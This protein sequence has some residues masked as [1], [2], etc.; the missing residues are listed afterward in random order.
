MLLYV[1]CYDTPCDKR[2]KKIA[3]LLEGYGHRVQ[4]S[5]FECVLPPNKYQE[6]KKRLRKRYKAGE[7]CIRF[8]P[9]SQHTIGQ[10]ELWGGPP[11]A[12]EPGSVII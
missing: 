12:Q 10:V 9:I 8:Y 2:R 3:D 4:Y 5:V 11:L 7:D 1:V 6:L